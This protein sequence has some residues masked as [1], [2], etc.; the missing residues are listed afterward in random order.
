MQVKMR[1][2]DGINTFCILSRW[3]SNFVKDY[4]RKTDFCCMK[5]LVSFL[6]AMTFVLSA[7]AQVNQPPIGAFG[8]SKSTE[9]IAKDLNSGR[10]TVKP[11]PIKKEKTLADEYE[12][13]RELPKK[14]PELE[15][16]V[17][18]EPPLAAPAPYKSE[19]QSKEGPEFG[20]MAPPPRSAIVD[21]EDSNQ[22]NSLFQQARETVIGGGPQG[23]DEYRSFLPPDDTRRN[24]LEIQVAPFFLYNDSNSPYWYRSYSN[25][26]PGFSLLADIWFTPSFG[27]EVGYKKSIGGSVKASANSENHISAGHEWLS[28]GLRF[29]RFFGMGKTVPVFTFGIDY[30][31]YY[32]KV[33]SDDPLRVRLKMAGPRLVAETKIPVS[34]RFQWV[35]GLEVTPFTKAQEQST[36]VTHQSGTEN[37]TFGFGV[38]AGGEYKL[39]RTNRMFYRLSYYLERSLYSGPASRADPNSG[40]TPSSVPV[41]NSF[42]MFEFG[43]IWG[44]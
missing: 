1:F 38:S 33:P 35:Y 30:R 5:S 32:F 41:N 25:F 16:D 24:L 19:V 7:Q 27:V 2:R 29:R 36:G 14:K 40:V 8:N 9:P 44:R 22:E 39:A 10:Y 43:F 21:D 23:L 4:Q 6:I 28:G 18:P 15:T 3:R 17:K 42:T 12:L 31:E 26:A 20:N 11:K 37:E 34:Q 13:A